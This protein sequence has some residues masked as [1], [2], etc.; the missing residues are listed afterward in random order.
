[1]QDSRPFFVV[2]SGR[3]G[4]AM[5]VKALG[6]HPEV[7]AEHEYMVQHVQ[8]LGVRRY[9]GL[10]PPQEAREVLSA[11]HAAAVRY[12]RTPL[13]GD[14][15]NK[16]S[17]LIGDLAALFPEARW[18]HLVRDGRKVSSSYL[19]KLADE[20]YDDRS[21]RLLAAY[22]AD[23]RRTTAPPPEKPYWWPQPRRGDP[24]AQ[25]FPR[26]A[27]FERIA[28]H[29]AE[30]N[31]VILRDLDAIDQRRRL[32]VRLE[33]LAGSLEEVERLFAFLGLSCGHDDA[34]LF[35]RPYNV[36]RPVDYALTPEQTANFE[37]IAGQMME[38][39]GYADR[40]EYATAY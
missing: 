10:A 39:L 29:W 33:D 30:V 37:Q 24:W 38:T 34:A 35:D 2:S 6:R 27:Q 19:H 25:E 22:L 31:R 14:S 15:S 5:I 40:A 17:W 32:F 36:G 18:I 16:L 28:W 3:S 13:W 23:P 26:F 21:T 8:P 12:A 7:T 4:T 11:T 1:M 9:A 20:C